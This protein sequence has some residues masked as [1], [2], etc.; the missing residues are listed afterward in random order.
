MQEG[1]L[2]RPC[3]A[4]LRLHES[5]G[6]SPA[7]RCKTQRLQVWSRSWSPL[8]L[9]KERRSQERV[10]PHGSSS[11]H[12]R[13]PLPHPAFPTHE[14][15]TAGATDGWR[16][17]Q[18]RPTAGGRGEIELRRRRID[19]SYCRLEPC[20]RAMPRGGGAGSGRRSPELL[21][22][23]ESGGGG[24][25]AVKRDGGEGAIGRGGGASVGGAEAEEGV[26][27]EAPLPV[28]LLSSRGVNG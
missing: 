19:L 18:Q 15:L 21:A 7:K 1:V 25:N 10:A 28:C 13:L 24:T 5:S 4:G 9:R 16:S 23:G 12:P 11:S 22:R 17:R 14:P 3:L 20:C 6:R 8:R 27:A 2:F 26:R